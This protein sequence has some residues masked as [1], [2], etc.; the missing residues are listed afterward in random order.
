MTVAREDLVFVLGGVAL[1][2]ILRM[3]EDWYFSRK[4]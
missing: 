4:Q 1:G 3:I 2:A